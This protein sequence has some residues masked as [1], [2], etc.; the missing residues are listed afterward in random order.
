MPP[1]NSYKSFRG[2]LRSQISK[3]RNSGNTHLANEI[4]HILSLLTTNIYIAAHR[5]LQTQPQTALLDHIKA[6][7]EENENNSNSTMSGQP[8]E[9]P[10]QPRSA[11]RS[12]FT[13]VERPNP[14]SMVPTIC[15]NPTPGREAATPTEMNQFVANSNESLRIQAVSTALSQALGV[16]SWRT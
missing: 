10:S 15:T 2:S 1:Y 9:T 6:I 3:L 16:L 11:F 8:P 13:P 7:I 14:N 12:L 5:R 4:D